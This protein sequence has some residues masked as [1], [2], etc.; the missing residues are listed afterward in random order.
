LIE[1]GC[2]RCA[3]SRFGSRRNGRPSRSWISGPRQ[4]ASCRSEAVARMRRVRAT[5]A[6]ARSLAACSPPSLGPLTV[7][8]AGYCGWCHGTISGEGKRGHRQR[9][10]GQLHQQQQVVITG[11]PVESKAAAVRT[12]MD[13]DP[14]ALPANSNGD[15]LHPAGTGGTPITRGVAIEV[16]G[17][18]AGRAMIAVGSARR[19]VG[20]GYATVRALERA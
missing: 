9:Q 5:V 7:R 17:P 19:V 6:E 1:R 3:R 11:Y 12:A 8:L 13:E 15:R 18:E 16:P 10:R 20:Y 4:A 2:S 14:P